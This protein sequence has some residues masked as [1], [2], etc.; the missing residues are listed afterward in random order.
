MSTHTVESIRA[1]L[2]AGRAVLRLVKTEE[3]W[4]ASAVPPREHVVR[5]WSVGVD[6]LTEDGRSDGTYGEWSLRWYE[7]G[8]SGES[9]RVEAFADSWLAL[10]AVEGYWDAMREAARNDG[11]PDAVFAALV[12][13]GFE[14]RTERVQP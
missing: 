14:D 1:D 9:V 13:I 11:T 4:Y 7:F 8:Y 2:A 5:D 12:G 3:A 10:G 6:A